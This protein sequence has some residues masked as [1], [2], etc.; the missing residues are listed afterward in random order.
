MEGHCQCLESSSA[1]S[2][3]YHRHMEEEEEARNHVALAMAMK[4][5]ELLST[6]TAKIKKNYYDYVLPMTPASMPPTVGLCMLCFAFV[7]CS[8]L[9]PGARFCWQSLMLKIQPVSWPVEP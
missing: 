2:G 9:L 4:R 8:A 5:E 1:A 3:V 6:L 7:V